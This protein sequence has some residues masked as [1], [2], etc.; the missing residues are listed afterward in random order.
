MAPPRTY[1]CEALTLKHAPIGETDLLVTFYTRDQGKLRAVA[2]GARRSNSKL[3]GHL[4][5]LTQATLSFA[6][7]RT[8]DYVTQV[9]VIESFGGLKADLDSI[10]RG[11]YVAE[12]IDGFGSENGAN[13]SLFNLGI[14]TLH[15]ISGNRETEL[16][17]RCF[18]LRLLDASGLKPELYRCVECRQEL[19]PGRHRFS[20][21]LGGTLCLDCRPPETNVLPLSVQVLKVLRLLDRNRPGSIQPLRISENLRQELRIL[22]EVTLEY[23]LDLQI[24]SNS[25]MEQLQRESQ[26]AVYT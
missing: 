24:R 2:R 16:P 12:L 11:F 15:A 9:Q 4:E 17:L 23:W 7:G 3:V 10:S 8:L 6:H 14:E 26:S 21:G 5:P 20:P 18:D 25:F 22:L 19:Q 1:Q 13:E